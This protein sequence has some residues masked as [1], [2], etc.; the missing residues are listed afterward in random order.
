MNKLKTDV[1][2][3]GSG[4]AGLGAAIAAAEKGVSV[5]VIE[6]R[7]MTGGISVTGMGIFAVES[8]HQRA[9]NVQFNRDDAFKLFMQKSDWK[10]DA[11]LVRAYINKTASTIDWLEAMGVVFQLNDQLTFPECINQTGHLVVSP[12]RG[13]GP[14]ATAHMIQ[15]MQAE[16]ERLGVEVM[17]DTA[18][19]SLDKSDSGYIA[20]LEHLDEGQSQIQAK[21]VVMASG[22]YSNNKKMLAEN[23]F[24][25]SK[26]VWVSHKVPLTGEGIQMAWD[27]G[28]VSDGMCLQNTALMPGGKN[29]FQPSE[30]T[31]LI[32]W[33]LPYLWVNQLGQRFMDEGDGNPWY[34][35]NAVERQP[36]RVWYCIIDSDTLDYLEQHGVDV[37]GY[38]GNEK[39]IEGLIRK[40]LDKG[41]ES[42]SVADSIGE[43]ADMTGIPAKSLK[44]SIDEYNQFCSKG[45]DEEFA[46]NRKFLRPVSKPK[47]YAFKRWIGAY[48]TVGGIKIN[49]HA[50]VTDK[51]GLPI[52]GFYAAGDCANGTHTH[53][54]SLVYILWGSTLGFAVNS[55]RIAG[56]SAADFIT[57]E[58]NEAE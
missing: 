30:L 45:I 33:G 10:P 57:D 21:T 29:T 26:D 19:K 56:E 31:S 38:L 6:K 49:E 25:L 27:L 11:K 36:G 58:Q 55:G 54:Y 18:V 9:R 44:K 23:G 28:A 37:A 35:C 48:G 4:A 43:L 51:A 32:S 8:H 42:I 50:E 5:S 47:F 2:V 52:P 39:D 15:C 14:A 13:I 17:T 40:A 12:K 22:G 16:A 46:K 7:K 41:T 20:V 1:L 53:N 3:I 24:E 34:T